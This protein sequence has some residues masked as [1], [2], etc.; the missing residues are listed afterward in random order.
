M[1]N[2]YS[3]TAVLFLHPVSTIH[4]SW[5]HMESK[6]LPLRSLQSACHSLMTS[7][8]PCAPMSHERTSSNRS[9]GSG[10][11][12]HTQVAKN[13]KMALILRLLRGCE[14]LAGGTAGL[15]RRP[16]YPFWHVAQV[17]SKCT[18]FKTSSPPRRQDQSS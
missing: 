9:S 15:S 5:N 4:D 7:C 8:R 2:P 18:R 11:L 10:R 13:M 3:L 12:Q 17:T 14:S 6:T 1:T 16:M